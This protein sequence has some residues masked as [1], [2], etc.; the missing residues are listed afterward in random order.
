MRMTQRPRPFCGRKLSRVTAL[1]PKQKT[2]YTMTEGLEPREYR[3]IGEVTARRLDEE[4]TWMTERGDTLHGEAGD[5]LV[6]SADGGQRTVGS[7][8]FFDLYEPVSQGRFRRKGTVGAV[9]AQTAATVSTLEGLARAHPGDWIVTA[10]DGSSW[11]VPD[12]V[13]RKSY[14]PV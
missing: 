1:G 10:A 11:P 2:G 7:H 4:L 9:R 12:E 8:E 14:A 6:E 13:F 5:W 3:R